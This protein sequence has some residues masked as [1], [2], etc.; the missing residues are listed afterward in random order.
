VPAPACRRLGRHC[1]ALDLTFRV[2]ALEGSEDH[3]A[4]WLFGHVERIDFG[5]THVAE[6]ELWCAARVHV[7]CRHLTTE[8]A[9]AGCRAY[10]YTG[11]L[12]PLTRP[13]QPRRLGGDRFRIVEHGTVVDREMPHPTRG[14]HPLPMAPDANPCAT[15]PC[16]TSDHTRHAACCRDIRVDVAV[17]RRDTHT[18]ALLRNRKSPYLCKVE[19]EDDD[20]LNVE[21]ISA[22]GYLQEDGLHCDLH[23]RKR[24]DGRPAKPEMCSHWPKKR[25]GLHP[26]CAFRSHKISL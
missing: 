11:R 12:P 5:P 20:L 4:T 18:E 9:T 7:P 10:G 22:C 13:E 8:G 25:T 3:D 17:P 2:S 26:G 6:D 23:D 24:A 21:I 15:A 1:L 19:R 14:R 16:R